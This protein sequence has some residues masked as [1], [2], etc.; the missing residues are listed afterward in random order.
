MQLTLMFD[1]VNQFSMAAREGA[2]TALFERDGMIPEGTTTNAKVEQ[3]VLRYL[4]AQGFAP[5]QLDVSICFPGEPDRIFDLDDDDNALQLFEV[6]IGLAMEQLLFVPPPGVEDSK[7]LGS[8]VFRNSP[9]R[10]I[11]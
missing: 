7:L 9:G 11:Q 5:D 3:E 10:L 1:T 6:R 4:A 2:R 8:V